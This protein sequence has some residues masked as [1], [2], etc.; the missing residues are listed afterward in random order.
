MRNPFAIRDHRN[1]GILSR[2]VFSL[3]RILGIPIVIDF[4]WVFIF[5][6]ITYSMYRL[7]YGIYHP[8]YGQIG[9]LLVA[10]AIAAI[11]FGSILFHELAHSVVARAFQ[12]PILGITLFLFGGVARLGAEV[13]RPIEEFLVAVAGPLASFLLA[14]LFW[15]VSEFIPGI[16]MIARYAALILAAINLALAIFNLIPGFPMDGGRILRAVVWKATGSLARATGAAA[17]VGMVAALGII[18]WGAWDLLKSMAAGGG[19]NGIW[20][21]LI[22]G[23]ILS[24]NRM[25]AAQARIDARR[26]RL[27]KLIPEWE[28]HLPYAMH[29]PSLL[30]QKPID[31]DPTEVITL[32]YPFTEEENDDRPAHQP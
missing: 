7:L 28:R 19:M 16:P 9:V 4:S 15:V 25:S 5:V 12:V 22:G 24:A 30:A 3:G 14:L 1:G 8:V 21:I 27:T 20:R 13:K 31:T 23:F 18:A 6:L 29:D 10:A 32:P 26:E 17:A 11:Y 2:R